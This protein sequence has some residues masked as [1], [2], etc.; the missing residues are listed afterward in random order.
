MTDEKKMQQD[1]PLKLIHMDEVEATNTRWLWYPY[2]PR[3]SRAIPE[4]AR[5]HWCCIWQRN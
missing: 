1:I 4:R 5:Q 2:I 3:L